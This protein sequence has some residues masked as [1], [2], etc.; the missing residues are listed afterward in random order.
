MVDR[1]EI[2]AVEAVGVW[3]E[4][5]HL[6]VSQPDAAAPGRQWPPGGVGELGLGHGLSVD[7]DE[8]AVAAHKVPSAGSGGLD[9]QRAGAQIAACLSE[10]PDRL[11]EA[12]DGQRSRPGR[13]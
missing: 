7:G 8:R 1:A 3:S 6:G 10:R 2:A 5:K 11:R 4:H 9:E 13:P 12:D